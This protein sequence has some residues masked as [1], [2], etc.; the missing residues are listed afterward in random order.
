MNKAQ[1]LSS[2]IGMLTSKLGISVTGS[3]ITGP[4]QRNVFGTPI[5]GSKQTFTAS[6]IFD[7]D[8][9]DLIPTLAGGKAK[10]IINLITVPGTFQTGDELQ[11]NAHT[12][13]VEGIQ[14]IPFM[15]LDTADFV[16][17]A[18]EVD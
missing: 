17:A 1:E 5:D 6:V 3:R 8:K 18:R 16:K 12:Y 9:L 7:S 15:G 2:N 10:E 4:T 14:P 11:Y 13:K